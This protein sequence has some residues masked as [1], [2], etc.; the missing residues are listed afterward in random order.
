MAATPKEKVRD[1]LYRL[2]RSKEEQL[3]L[4]ALLEL[5]FEPRLFNRLQTEEDQK[6]LVSKATDFEDNVLK[7]DFWV[8]IDIRG[9]YQWIPVQVKTTRRPF[10]AMRHGKI[11][12]A[13]KRVAFFAADRNLIENA[14]KEDWESLRIFRK[15]L[16]RSLRKQNREEKLLTPRE[17][18]ELLDSMQCI[19][20]TTQRK[21]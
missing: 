7:I 21:E 12:Y 15:F 9:T 16:L 6:L 19:Q 18:S 8:H 10:R 13:G 2:C 14:Q 5:Q 17:V 20:N 3:F 11:E 4:W 1:I